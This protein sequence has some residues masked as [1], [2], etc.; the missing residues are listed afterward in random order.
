MMRWGWLTCGCVSSAS[1]IPLPLP[2]AL[3]CPHVACMVHHTTHAPTVLLYVSAPVK[4]ISMCSAA[5]QQLTCRSR[6][7]LDH[8]PLCMLAAWHVLETVCSFSSLCACSQRACLA[9]VHA[10]IPIPCFCFFVA[11]SP[12]QPMGACLGASAA[13]LYQPCSRRPTCA[14]SHC[15]AFKHDAATM[16]APVR[17]YVCGAT[18]AEC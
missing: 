18:K 14:T 3:P 15:L 2:L 10:I 12:S 4:P 11:L 13:A 8:M 16:C 6:Y 7:D 9:K 1:C 5:L 17:M